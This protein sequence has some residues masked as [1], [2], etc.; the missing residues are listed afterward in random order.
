MVSHRHLNIIEA[1]LPL[2]WAFAKVSPS[3]GLVQSSWSFGE[4]AKWLGTVCL[5]MVSVE[6]DQMLF[7]KHY[8]L[9]YCRH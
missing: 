8:Y 3:L 2:H 1:S 6:P 4:S 7:L 9:L 5:N